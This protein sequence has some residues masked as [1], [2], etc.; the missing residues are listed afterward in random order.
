MVS[1]NLRNICPIGSFHQ[2][3]VNIKKYLKP[4]PRNMMVWNMYWLSTFKHGYFCCT[5]VGFQGGRPFLRGLL[6]YWPPSLSTNHAPIS[7]MLPATLEKKR[8]LVRIVT[9]GCSN[10]NLHRWGGSSIFPMSKKSPTAPTERT[11]K[12]T[13]ES[14]S[15]SNF[16][17][18]SVGK[19]PF[20]FWWTIVF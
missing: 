19:V 15:S 8:S 3:R 4:P 10:K 2:V 9:K 16:L 7:M 18:G 1:T 13:W 5:Y 11:P 20:N 17:R 12:Q 6:G 14:N